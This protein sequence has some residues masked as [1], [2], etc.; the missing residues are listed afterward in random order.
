MIDDVLAL[1]AVI[2]LAV[3]AF[4]AFATAFQYA[5]TPSVCQ[6]AKIALENPGTELHVYG[7]FRV[8]NDSQYVYLSCGLRIPL[9]RVLAINKTMGELVVGSTAG[10]RLYIK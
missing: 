2:A 9:S 6:A 5:S 1:A 10:G 3:I 4:L 7:K 8:W